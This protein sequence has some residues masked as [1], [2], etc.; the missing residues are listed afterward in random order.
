MKRTTIMLP[1][2]LKMQAYNRA[3]VM[4]ISL[5]ELIRKSLETILSQRDE[6]KPTE[7]S[8]FADNAVYEGKAP[9]YL[10]RNHDKYLY[11]EK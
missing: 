3:R 4:G 9:K 2:D 1:D 8:L 6:E 5:G 10:S 7:D 11:R